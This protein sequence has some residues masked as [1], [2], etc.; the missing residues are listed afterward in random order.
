MQLPKV[1]DYTIDGQ[2][3]NFASNVNKQMVSK[4]ANVGHN[5]SLINSSMSNNAI[6]LINLAL[7]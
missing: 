2:H 6:S 7:N 3:M 5:I 4:I 1:N